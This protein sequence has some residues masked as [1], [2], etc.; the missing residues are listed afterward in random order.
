[1]KNQAVACGQDGPGLVGDSVAGYVKRIERF[2][3]LRAGGGGGGGH[4]CP[5][6][7]QRVECER[8]RGHQARGAC[9]GAR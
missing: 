7:Q 3:G 5:A 8:L 9:G 4:G 6:Y 1:M 2:D